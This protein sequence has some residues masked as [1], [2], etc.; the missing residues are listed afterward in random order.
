MYDESAKYNTFSFSMNVLISFSKLS[1]SNCGS[2]KNF[3]K[4]ISSFMSS[5]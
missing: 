5:Q 4:D 3:S 2:D 1:R